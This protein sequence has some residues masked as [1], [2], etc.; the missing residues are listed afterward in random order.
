[1]IGIECITEADTGR[2][3]VQKQI[4]NND[5][6]IGNDG[7]TIILIDEID[8][9]KVMVVCVLGRLKQRMVVSSCFKEFLCGQ[10]R[11]YDNVAGMCDAIYIPV[12]V[13][14]DFGKFPVKGSFRY[15]CGDG[16]EEALGTSK[17]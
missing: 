8:I 4:S 3:T 16:K 15:Y 2:L 17:L 5:V 9:A 10:N 6:D 14:T 7:I 1:M 11:F 12:N 13:D